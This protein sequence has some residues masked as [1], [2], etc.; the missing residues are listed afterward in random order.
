MSHQPL[1]S[2]ISQNYCIQSAAL[3]FILLIMKHIIFSPDLYTNQLLLI[4][5]VTLPHKRVSTL[6]SHHQR[7]I[8]NVTS[9]VPYTQAF[10]HSLSVISLQSHSV[11]LTISTL[12]RNFKRHYSIQVSH[13]HTSE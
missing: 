12:L 10:Q 4:T 2:S 1:T 11:F 9:L 5:I 3:S 13:Q 8:S 6:L 7:L